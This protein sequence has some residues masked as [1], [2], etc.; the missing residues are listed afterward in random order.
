MDTN[1]LVRSLAADHGFRVRPVSTVLAIALVIALPFTAGMFM[2]RLG[3]RPDVMAATG[4]PFFLLKFAF[5]LALAAAS[6]VL[7]AR[8]VR[9]G[10]PIAGAGWLLAIPVVL[11]LAGIAVD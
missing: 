8:L 1:E 9:P 4:H 3:M 11:V 10:T 7:A 2:M 6:V 5:T